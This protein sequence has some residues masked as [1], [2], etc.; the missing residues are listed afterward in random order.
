MI[1]FV[2]CCLVA[3]VFGDSTTG[4]SGTF[5]NP[6][7]VAVEAGLVGAAAARNSSCFHVTQSCKECTASPS[8]A[9]CPSVD[10]DVSGILLGVNYKFTCNP[11][12]RFVNCIVIYLFIIIFWC[13]VF[14]F[15][16]LVAFF[17]WI[18][19]LETVLVLEW[20]CIYVFIRCYTCRYSWRV[21]FIILFYFFILKKKKSKSKSNPQNLNSTLNVQ[22]SCTTLPNWRQCDVNGSVLVI[23]VG[24]LLAFVCCCCCSGILCCV[25]RRKSTAGYTVV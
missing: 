4:S 6:L 3:S 10:I 18:L 1:L 8:C 20:K 5:D 2:V 15:L 13:I 23:G 22:I 21:S 25:C 7:C 16:I 9:F 19:F 24:V 12:V 17:N 14:S 11:T